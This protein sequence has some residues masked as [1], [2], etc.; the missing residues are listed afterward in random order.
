MSQDY[1]RIQNILSIDDVDILN[2][3]QKHVFLPL[4]RLL[5]IDHYID[6]NNSRRYCYI[7]N[8]YNDTTT[9]IITAKKEKL[10]Y[11]REIFNSD[12]DTDT[13]SDFDTDSE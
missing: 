4:S 13:D 10:C 11:A 7:L 8:N 2:S 3:S 6:S 9:K 1:I 12:T 5:S